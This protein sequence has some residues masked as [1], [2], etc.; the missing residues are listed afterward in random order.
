[1]QLNAYI[2][3]K[4]GGPFNGH[5]F[6]ALHEPLVLQRSPDVIVQTKAG[7]TGN[8]AQTMQVSQGTGAFFA[9]RFQAKGGEGMA[10]VSLFLLGELGR[11][12]RIVRHQGI[13]RSIQL[14][15]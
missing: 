14:L 3:Q 10:Q 4:G 8:P 11:N 5:T 2:G 6:V 15:L 12:K 7:R 1:M 9:V 13:Q